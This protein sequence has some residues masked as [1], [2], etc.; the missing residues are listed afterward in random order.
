MYCSCVF[1]IYAYRQH[2]LNAERATTSEVRRWLDEAMQEG[3]AGTADRVG[4]LAIALQR[5]SEEIKEERAQAAEVAGDY[6]PHQL[7]VQPCP[8]VCFRTM[9]TRLCLYACTFYLHTSMLCVDTA[10]M[11]QVHLDAGAWHERRHSSS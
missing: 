6:T 11:N 2:M 5:L 9:H 4:P 7:Q 8:A 10:S 1:S 3:R